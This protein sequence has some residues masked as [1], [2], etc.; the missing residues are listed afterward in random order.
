MPQ[1]DLLISIPIGIGDLIHISAQLE[2]V[3]HKYDKIEIAF[4]PEL[5]VNRDENYK[6]FVIEFCNKI[7]VGDK[8]KFVEHKNG[9]KFRNPSLLYSQEWIIP[10]KPC[11]KNLLCKPIDNIYGNYI[12]VSTK[13]RQLSH[14]FYLEI[15]DKYFEILNKFTDK[16][17]IMILGEREIEY[18]EEYQYY[19]NEHIYS[20]YSDYIKYLPADKIIDLTIPKLG[21]TTPDLD[22]IMFDC[23]LM[24]HAK[25]NF[26]IGIGG[27]FCLS[28]A[29]GNSVGYRIDDDHV[30]DLLYSDE[31]I[32]S[33]A[34]ITKNKEKFFSK[35]EELYQKSISG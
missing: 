18:N 8:F 6:Q 28:L 24:A 17:Q 19:T 35:M 27:N 10:K 21:I 13:V 4:Q 5:F 22:K 14:S 9:M 1:N 2:S 31:N 3:Q 16:F 30:A 34:Y 15:R 25:Y 12:C 33:D 11:L 23:A 26:L 7:F 29:V 20:L 32:Y